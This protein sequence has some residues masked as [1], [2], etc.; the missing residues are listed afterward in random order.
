[1]EFYLP[2]TINNRRLHV[3]H[4]K[5]QP[6]KPLFSFIINNEEDTPPVFAINAD[7][8]KLIS[9]DGYDY[10][11]ELSSLQPNIE[12]KENDI[13]SLPTYYV[14]IEN[15]KKDST[16]NGLS[17]CGTFSSPE[18][19]FCVKIDNTVM[20]KERT[21][22]VVVVR[23]KVKK[24][25]GKIIESTY[26]F[27][28]AFKIHLCNKNDLIEAAMDFGSEASQVRVRADG[29]NMLLVDAF[30]KFHTQYDSN[31][32]TQYWKEANIEKENQIKEYW[33]D[34][35]EPDLYKSVFFIHTKPKK[36][37]KE[38][39]PNKNVDNTFIKAL[40]PKNVS[41][42][43]LEDLI[44]LPNLKL[45]ELLSSSYWKG[46]VDFGDEGNPFDGKK[47]LNLSSPKANDGILSMVLNNFLHCILKTNYSKTKSKQFLRFILLM[48][49]VYYQKKVY[50]I[51]KNIYE[52]FEK[53]KLQDVEYEQYA[54][55]EV[56]MISESD[57]AF[58][59]AINDTQYFTQQN[60]AGECF[61]IID[62]GKGTTDFSILKQHESRSKFDSIYKT[63]IPASGQY[64]TYAFYEAAKDFFNSNGIS[65]KDFV[66]KAKKERASLLKFMDTLEQFKTADYENFRHNSEVQITDD[67]KASLKNLNDITTFLNK[68][69]I[70]KK[71]HIPNTKEKV[72]KQIDS[73]VQK[74][75]ESI[76]AGIKQEKNCKQFKQV[77]LTGRG[78]LFSPFQEAVK[79]MLLE[80]NWV[81][82]KTD[83][84][85]YSKDSK[86]RA[87]I[88]CLDGA[89]ATGGNGN[90]G[91]KT[92]N[93]VEINDNS[94]L[95]GRP[96][97]FVNVGTKNPIKKIQA[98]F[99]QKKMSYNRGNYLDKDFFYNGIRGISGTNIDIMFGGR[100]LKNDENENDFI[101]R[102]IYFTGKELIVQYKNK[103]IS[104]IDEKPNSNGYYVDEMVKQ[105]LFPFYSEYPE[106]FENEN[107]TKPVFNENNGEDETN[108][109]EV[110]IIMPPST[111]DST[112]K[113]TQIN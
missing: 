8:I 97:C 22:F 104:K 111:T 109:T 110:P 101:E 70:E 25:K 2:I 83:I 23:S 12:Y 67:A 45:M 64:L 82:K 59:G 10:N 14:N 81:S 17:V 85:S 77:L 90:E 20:P 105:T 107:I 15:K 36:T 68:T 57:A 95:I 11:V 44:I 13:D 66:K 24:E 60:A 50:T 6:D 91:G 96:Y 92:A 21:T 74:I 80:K 19:H 46:Q 42:D 1:M 5:E 9:T 103:K 30:E 27:S 113:N 78:F 73:L 39:I 93:E 76:T 54:G 62:A 34:D 37:E 49:N 61:L 35:L 65:L 99:H 108:K 43:K 72:K 52:D 33:Q 98:F 3:C 94:E 100:K 51:I 58:V 31:Y 102:I 88:L 87:K 71:C 32:W 41:S 63:G 16:K 48:P 18:K 56:Q 29:T 55:I 4:L 53:I 69:L 40:V 75:E 112:H 38:E 106:S 84:H 7:D 28:Y 47:I 86:G 89:F 79:T 26:S